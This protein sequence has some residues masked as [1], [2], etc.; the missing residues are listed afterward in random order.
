MRTHVSKMYVRILISYMN[1][2]CPPVFSKSQRYVYDSSGA[3]L[4]IIF[5]FTVVHTLFILCELIIYIFYL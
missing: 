4:D 2:E 1:F 5:T 3:L